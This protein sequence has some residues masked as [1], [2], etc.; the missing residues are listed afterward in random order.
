MCGE[1]NE[2]L[3]YILCE[4]EALGALRHEQLGSFFLPRRHKEFG[5]E[6]LFLNFSTPVYKM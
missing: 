4:C 2:I 1:E 3:A 5:A 6:I